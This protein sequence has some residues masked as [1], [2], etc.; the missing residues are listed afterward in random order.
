VCVCALYV[1]VCVSACVCVGGGE[2]GGLSVGVE[3]DNHFQLPCVLNDL[4]CQLC[5]GD[6]DLFRPL[7][8][9]T[10]RVVAISTLTPPSLLCILCHLLWGVEKKHSSSFIELDLLIGLLYAPGD[11]ITNSVQQ[12]VNEEGVALSGDIPFGKKYFV[13][14]ALHQVLLKGHG[15][16]DVDIGLDVFSAESLE[17][18]M[19]LRHAVL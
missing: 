13:V 4:L 9:S 10:E 5:G 7:L 2:W 3:L 1:C 16:M 14:A 8:L 15:V 11:L 18:C 6:G 19:E 12:D 17:F